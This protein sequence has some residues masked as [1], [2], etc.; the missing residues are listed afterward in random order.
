MGR[1]LD[2]LMAAALVC[3]CSNPV[4]F[5]YFLII[6]LRFFLTSLILEKC[7][8]FLILFPHV[9]IMPFQSTVCTHVR[10]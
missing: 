5:L 6:L 10:V 3:I 8:L 1:I 7:S 2:H 4:L 9:Q